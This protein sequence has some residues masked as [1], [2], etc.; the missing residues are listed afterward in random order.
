MSKIF[1][2]A[3]YLRS[4]HTSKEGKVP[5]NMRVSLR[6]ERVSFGSTGCFCDPHQWNSAKSRLRGRSGEA[7]S[8]NDELDRIESDLNHIFRRYEFS[9]NLSLDAIKADYLGEKPNEASFLEFYAEFLKGVRSE[10]GKSRG[11]A[12]WQLKLPPSSSTYLTQ[13]YSP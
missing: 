11:Y 3:F 8:V 1:K 5:I 6:G 4:N 9:E 10:V 12:S 7:M 2:V 13:F